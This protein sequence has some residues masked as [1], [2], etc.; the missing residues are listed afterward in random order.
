[1][2]KAYLLPIFIF[3][4]SLL[5]I[6][7]ALGRGNDMQVHFLD[8]GQGD[9]TLVQ[10]PSGKNILIDTGRNRE[11]L[12]VLPQQLSFWDRHID[13]IFITH[14]DV[15]HAGGAPFLLDRYSVGKIFLNFQDDTGSLPQNILTRTNKF[16]TPVSQTFAGDSFMFD[17]IE[18]NILWPPRSLQIAD[19]NDSSIIMLL[20]F[21]NE[22]LLLSG[23][24]SIFVES[25]LIDVFDSFVAADILKA[26]HHG[27]KTSSFLSFLKKVSPEFVIVSAGCD[28]RYGH[29]NYEVLANIALVGAKTLTTCNDGTTSFHFSKDNKTWERI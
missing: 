25:K 17:G 7:Y 1:M 15:D 8:V 24:A 23:D 4:L 16:Q 27:S 29:P 6:S 10:T 22:K 19:R 18:I 21:H 13:Y 11:I 5:M 26:G 14:A 20:S 3:L 28:N 9:A 12:T 2:T